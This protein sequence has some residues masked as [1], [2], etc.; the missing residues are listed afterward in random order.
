MGREY[1][2]RASCCFVGDDVKNDLLTWEVKPGNRFVEQDEISCRGNGSSND[3]PLAF[4][5]REFTKSTRAQVRNFESLGCGIDSAA[6]FR[7]KTVE[8][9][10]IAAHFQHLI[11]RNRHPR[12]VSL[13]LGNE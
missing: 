9:P 13:V 12:M 7:P 1:D 4:T 6:V 11:D 8:E 10:P 3:D 5:A 2:G